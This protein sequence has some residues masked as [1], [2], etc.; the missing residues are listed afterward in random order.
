[1]GPRPLVGCWYIVCLILGTVYCG[2]L[3]AFSLTTLE[4]AVQ[5]LDALIA[6]KPRARILVK[7]GSLPFEVLVRNTLT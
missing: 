4:E 6:R 2:R 5:S 3:T 7:N 1:M